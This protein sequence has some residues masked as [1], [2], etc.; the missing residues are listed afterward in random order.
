[1]QP[2]WLGALSVYTAVQA[3]EGKDVPAFIKVPLPVIDDSTIDG[4]LAR[5]DQ[6][7]ADGYI[8]SPYDLA[9]FDQLLGLK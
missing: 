2:N 8:Y 6:F 5:A 9:M 7:P 4:Y 3:L 1:M